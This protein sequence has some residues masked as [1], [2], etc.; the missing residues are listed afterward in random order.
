MKSVQ[1]V[2]HDGHKH[3]GGNNNRRDNRREATSIDKYI[4]STA[5]TMR[6]LLL[7]VVAPLCHAFTTTKQQSAP[8][9]RLDQRPQPHRRFLP[10]YAAT[11]QQ[12]K[13]QQ[14]SKTR[15]SSNKD[16]HFSDEPLLFGFPRDSVA[17]PL[18]LL[19]ASQFI[20]FIGV[21]A[22]IPS[23]PLY[24]KEIGTFHCCVILHYSCFW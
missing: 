20:L 24:G 2:Q 8:F 13:Q 15:T 7:L 12:Q 18:A 17:K 22:V 5:S 1:Q 21:G 23:I 6:L 10:L 19:L 14:Q 4:L 9:H 11:K 3:R 16:E